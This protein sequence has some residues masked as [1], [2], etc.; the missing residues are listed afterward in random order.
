MKVKFEA[1]SRADGTYSSLPWIPDSTIVNIIKVF[2]EDSIIGLGPLLIEPLVEMAKTDSEYKA[3]TILVISLLCIP[4][5]AIWIIIFIVK[6]VVYRVK[7]IFGKVDP[8]TDVDDG[9]DE[10]VKAST[11]QEEIIEEKVTP[12]AHRR[13]RTR[14]D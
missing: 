5:V 7:K 12:K 1:Q 8:D 9:G 3:L 2:Y 11:I 13:L 14:R 4:S 10:V 6:M